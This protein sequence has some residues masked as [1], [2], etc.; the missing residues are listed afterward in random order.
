MRF[1]IDAFFLT[2]RLCCVGWPFLYVDVIQSTAFLP[3]SR[4]PENVERKETQKKRESR[5]GRWPALLSR[6]R[7][8]P[9]LRH[10]FKLETDTS[11]RIFSTFILYF[12]FVFIFSFH[13]SAQFRRL[14]SIDCY[15]K[16][17]SEKPVCCCWTRREYLSSSRPPPKPQQQQHPYY[18]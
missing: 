11:A 17:K 5:R 12:C 3:G 4:L 7:L 8:P 6:G 14:I 15:G 16:E 18:K 2:R 13:H 1:G 10:Y 9:D